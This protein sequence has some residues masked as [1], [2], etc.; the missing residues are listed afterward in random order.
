MPPAEEAVGFHLLPSVRTDPKPILTLP[1][2]SLKVPEPTDSHLSA[3]IVSL[4]EQLAQQHLLELAAARTPNELPT[5][6]LR[7]R[8]GASSSGKASP[9]SSASELLQVSDSP[10]SERP[11]HVIKRRVSALM[12]QQKEGL[13]EVGA[14][15]VAEALIENK[16]TKKLARARTTKEKLQELVPQNVQ[17]VN[18]GSSID[19]V[20]RPRRSLF[21]RIQDFLQ[22]NRY[23]LVIALLLSINVLWMAVEAQLSGTLV[24]YD[25]GFYKETFMSTN[26]WR[27]RQDS[28]PLFTVIFALDVIVRIAVLRCAF[29]TV[30]MNY[31]DVAVTVISIVEVVVVYSSPTLLEDVNVNPVL[32]RLLR[33]GKLARAVRMVTMNSVLNSLQILTRCLASSAT[34]LFWSFCLLTFFQCVFGMVASTL[35]R[36]FITDETQNLQYR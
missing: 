33:L 8:Y 1:L 15:A 32:F 9:K 17:D 6:E 16:D 13:R 19:D 14:D 26:D 2:G 28:V 5:E 20:P 21:L 36:D 24:G 11:A 10:R 22:S 23:E 3:A 25:L 29:W 34:M 27:S 30:T 7:G 18:S 31:L 12:C 4:F 35:C